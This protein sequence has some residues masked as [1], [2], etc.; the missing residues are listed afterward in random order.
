MPGLAQRQ[1]L[2]GCSASELWANTFRERSVVGR[3][4]E[5]KGKGKEGTAA[6]RRVLCS[7]R[8]Q[9][10]QA[11]KQ[12]RVS[13]GD[14]SPHQAAAA[15]AVAAVAAKQV[16]PG[17]SG[18][19]TTG[20]R[21]DGGAV[22]S[23][24]AAASTRSGGLLTLSSLRARSGSTVVAPVSRTVTSTAPSPRPATTVLSAFSFFFLLLFHI[25][26]RIRRRRAKAARLVPGAEHRQHVRPL[27]RWSLWPTPSPTFTTAIVL[28]T[29]KERTGARLFLHAA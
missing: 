11:N 22:S 26:E 5:G 29:V 12:K 1:A 15:P 9:T 18:R 13:S 6:R 27:L 8:H 3:G 17:G 21:P 7:V 24:A 19:H 2:T 4:P 14:D 28:R 16:G 10:M 23:F 20:G 25:A